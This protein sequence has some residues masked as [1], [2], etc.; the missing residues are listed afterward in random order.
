MISGDLTQRI[1]RDA[2]LQ[3][4]WA[5]GLR[6][7]Y[8]LRARGRMMNE[9]E[10]LEHL[11]VIDD[12]LVYL[13]PQP[14]VGMGLVEQDP[15]YPITHP[16]A[17]QGL[18]LVISTI[19][20]T[21]F[22]VAGWGMAL[23]QSQHWIVSTFPGLGLGVLCI[24]FARHAFG[25]RATNLK[26][27]LLAMGLYFISLIPTFM[28]VPNLA[29]ISFS[30]FFERDFQSVTDFEEIPVASSRVSARETPSTKSI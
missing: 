14:P 28:L 10:T 26:I 5:N 9:R 16:Y 19:L 6:R 22:W 2:G 4:Y 8:G 30:V 23:S 17:G 25:G 12:E 21:F 3:A 15:D 11:G 13:L 1:A 27:L 24:S 7:T 20:L 18:I 29:N